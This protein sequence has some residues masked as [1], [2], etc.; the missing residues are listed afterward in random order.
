MP[1]SKKLNVSRREWQ[2]LLIEGWGKEN[3]PG[4]QP[5]YGEG[6]FV[7][8]LVPGIFTHVGFCGLDVGRTSSRPIRTLIGITCP[9]CTRVLKKIAKRIGA[10][11]KSAGEA[12]AAPGTEG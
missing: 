10:D 3:E 8:H 7:Q 11:Q 6:R 4:G 1:K 5:W 12:V 2:R 9:G